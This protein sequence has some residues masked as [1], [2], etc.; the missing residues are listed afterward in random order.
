VLGTPWGVANGVMRRRCQ[1][2]IGNPIRFLFV[3][4]P[5]LI[6]LEFGLQTKSL[7]FAALLALPRHTSCATTGTLAL[8]QPW[9]AGRERGGLLRGLNLGLNPLVHLNLLLPSLVA[10][11]YAFV[12][13]RFPERVNYTF[14]NANK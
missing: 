6:N 1:N 2:L 13:S 12:L 9:S 8:Q 4:I 14:N 5:R 7:L 10:T 3:A 11:Y